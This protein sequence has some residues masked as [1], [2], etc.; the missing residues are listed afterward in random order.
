M[1]SLFLAATNDLSPNFWFGMIWVFIG[2]MVFSFVMLLA[3]RFKRC[4]RDRKSVV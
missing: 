1:K 2:I 4:P 3:N